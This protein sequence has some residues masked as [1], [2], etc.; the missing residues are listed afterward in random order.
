MA[1]FVTQDKR[2]TPRREIERNARIEMDGGTTVECTLSDVS[3]AGAKIAVADF[4]VVPDVFVLVLRDDLRK[5]CRV[6]RRAENFL[7]VMF[8][9]APAQSG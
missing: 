8:I 4:T 9:A 1:R 3:Q 6:V 2:T 5:W 7:G